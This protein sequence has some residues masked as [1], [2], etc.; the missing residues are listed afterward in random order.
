MRRKCGDNSLVQI[1]P[2]RAAVENHA[3]AGDDVGKGVQRLIHAANDVD[4]NFKS[5]FFR[6]PAILVCNRPELETGASSQNTAFGT[7]SF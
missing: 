5:R 1:Q 6:K 7:R 3:V 2:A 4:F